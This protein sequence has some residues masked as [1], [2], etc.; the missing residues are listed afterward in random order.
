MKTE[1]NNAKVS[2]PTIFGRCGR[3][4]VDTFMVKDIRI[5]H[6]AK[7]C[8]SFAPCSYPFCNQ[9]DNP[10]HSVEVCG[11]LN[12]MCTGCN[13]RG[14]SIRDHTH[15]SPLGLHSVFANFAHLGILTALPFLSRARGFPREV[16]DEEMR[17]DFYCHN[18]MAGLYLKNL[19]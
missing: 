14:H 1:K 16:Q 17:Y 3:C 7:D 4:G 2:N 12:G 9:K 5:G 19:Q 6:L 11:V 18:K 13:R 10:K 8:T 15:H